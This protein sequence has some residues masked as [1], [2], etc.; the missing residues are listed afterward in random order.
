MLADCDQFVGRTHAQLQNLSTKKQDADAAYKDAQQLGRK[1]SASA[2]SAAKR[3]SMVQTLP[4]KMHSSQA[5]ST[6]QATHSAAKKKRP[7][8]VLQ[9]QC[10]VQQ[11]LRALCWYT[12]PRSRGY[13]I[14]R[15]TAGS[16]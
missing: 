8:G 5:E 9:A 16:D 15:H 7:V 13:A 10:S 2:Q 1:H 3:R 14:L 4:A 6:A 12:W 11:P